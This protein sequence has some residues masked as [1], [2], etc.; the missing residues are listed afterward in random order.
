[1]EK[2]QFLYKKI[3][4]LCNQYYVLLFFDKFLVVNHPKNLVLDS[5]PYHF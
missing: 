4:L 5:P 1:M 3:Y 2:E